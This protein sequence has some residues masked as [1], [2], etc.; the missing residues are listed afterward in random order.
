MP[1]MRPP[2]LPADGASGSGDRYSSR[3]ADYV[4][5]R[6]GYPPALLDLLRTECN[7]SA[8]ADVA[9]VGSGTGLLSELLVA[10]GHRVYGVEP[11]R[12]CAS[13][14]NS[15]SDTIAAS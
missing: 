1:R 2:P 6:P 15:A 5:Y 14:P 10:D 4:Q 7:L 8:A 12:T 3:I 13:P 9:D 11:I